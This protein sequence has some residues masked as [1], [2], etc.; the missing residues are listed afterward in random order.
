[1]KVIRVALL[2]ILATAVLCAC[3]K[4]V[5]LT[6]QT[7]LTSQ[8]VSKGEVVE[9]TAETE[10]SLPEVVRTIQDFTQVEVGEYDETLVKDLDYHT[11]LVA[12][13]YDL[14]YWKAFGTAAVI[15]GYEPKKT[16][17]QVVKYLNEGA[18][19]GFAFLFQAFFD[20]K[21]ATEEM[22]EY[23]KSYAYYLTKAT[24]ENHSFADYM[25]QDYREEWYK[26]VGCTAEYNYDEY[27]RLIENGKS[28]RR[29][30]DTEYAVGKHKWI[31]GSEDWIKD[32]QELYE[33]IYDCYKSFDYM[34]ELIKAD[35]PTFFD[36]YAKDIYVVV[37]L[38]DD[39]E[40]SCMVNT[41]YG[42]WIKLSDAV[43]APHE[44]VHVFTV[45][46]TGA[47]YYWM[48]EG[49]AER[50]SL[51][52]TRRKGGP[53]TLMVQF[54]KG[55]NP[56][57]FWEGYEPSARQEIEPLM[58]ECR[59][60]FNSYKEMYGDEY[61]ES[62]YAYLAMGEKEIETGKNLFNKSVLDSRAALGNIGGN[63]IAL[64]DYLSYASATVLVNE[65]IKD[66]GADKVLTYLYV[67]GDFKSNFGMT[68]AEYLDKVRERGGYKLG[69]FDD[70]PYNNK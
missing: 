52:Y 32:A 22:I 2:G 50:Y 35:A 65:M 39:D 30:N 21:Y 64:S 27:D 68:S 34:E 33:T 29:A 55:D 44:Y 28:H 8:E 56:E 26:A 61:M 62:L 49:V 45:H 11:N 10:A 1:M 20:K 46:G 38:V 5:E 54:M 40:T 4:P 36:T 58:V 47:D 53:N 23:A 41:G 66:F 70:T 3:E 18:P 15:V 7:V 9:E 60:T 31:Y 42:G 24:L 57:G 67:G 43:P 16:Q 25:S 48:S 69:F 13:M 17:M 51:Y 14:P 19:K 6:E 12:D 63:R 59:E 37:E